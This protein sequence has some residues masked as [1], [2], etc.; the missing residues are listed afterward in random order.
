MVPVTLNDHILI[1]IITHLSTP[2]S[3]LFRWT[4]SQ[5]CRLQQTD[6]FTKLSNYPAFGIIAIPNLIITVHLATLVR[7]HPLSSP[8]F[9]NCWLG[10]EGSTVRVTLTTLVICKSDQQ[11]QL[12]SS[13][14]VAALHAESCV[15]AKNAK[16]SGLGEK[17][18]RAKS[19]SEQ[20]D[21]I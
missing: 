11:E 15:A 18:P 4:F 17:K 13:S 19:T 2:V 16:P 5:L 9:S 7:K 8:A 1:E 12:R 14:R 10:L 6:K 20:A 3:V 21:C